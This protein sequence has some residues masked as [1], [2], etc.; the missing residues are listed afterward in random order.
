MQQKKKFFRALSLFAN[1]G[2][3]ETYLK[4]TNTE[5]VL[6]NELDPAR[7]RFYQEMYPDSEM[8]CG[9]ITQKNIKDILLYKAKEKQVNL[10]M[11]TPPCQGMSIAGKQNPY[12]ERNTLICHAVELIR[13][14]EPKYVFIENVTQMLNTYIVYHGNEVLITDYMKQ[15]LEEFYHFSINSVDAADFGVPQTRK[16]AIILLTHKTQKKVWEIPDTTLFPKKTMRDA[17]GWLSPVEPVL[18]DRPEAETTELFPYFISHS[19]T[20]VI[21]SPYHRP[22]HHPYRQV[23]AML[24][25]PTGQTAF[26]NPDEFKPKKQDGTFVKGFRTT[27]KRQ[28]W[29]K[30]AATVTMANGSIS[31]Q[32]NVHPG[33][34]IGLDEHGNAL[35]SNPRVLTL[36]ELFL[37]SS[38]PIDWKPP[39]WAS[40][41]LIRKVIG[42][43]VPPLMVKRIFENLPENG[44]T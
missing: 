23:Y 11:A 16:R 25:T 17:I 26:D 15:E 6:A 39:Q 8:V 3:A 32:N 24:H 38:L 13:A 29:D 18:S 9:D 1:V 30:P 14:I 4:D 27:Y 33:H 2:I 44:N 36:F 28:T 10:I 41:N 21:V 22:P 42:E 19:K 31:S 34:F 20:A 35:Y 40:D 37:V 43:G 5:V 7:A 12:D